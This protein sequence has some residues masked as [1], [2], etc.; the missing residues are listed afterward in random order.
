MRDVVD[1]AGCTVLCRRWSLVVSHLAIANASSL[2]GWNFGFA[3][4]GLVEHFREV[5][6]FMTQMGVADLLLCFDCRLFHDAPCYVDDR[7]TR[8][9]SHLTITNASSLGGCVFL[10]LPQLT[11]SCS[12]YAQSSQV[13]PALY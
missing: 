13:G 5:L 11:L 2:G 10:A 12:G 7:V 8:D 3:L 6:K 4:G 9:V 1:I